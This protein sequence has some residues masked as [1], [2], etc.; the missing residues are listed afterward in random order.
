[1]QAAAD[2]LAATDRG[3]AGGVLAGF[4]D[5]DA[6]YVVLDERGDVLA[7]SANA[8]DGAAL[9]ALAPAQGS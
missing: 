3:E 7:A 4:G 2:L 9:A 6:A 5:D 8:G 1:M